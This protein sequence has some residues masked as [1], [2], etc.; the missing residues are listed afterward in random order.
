M[1]EKIIG[2]LKIGAIIFILSLI[3][4]YLFQFLSIFSILPKTEWVFYLCWAALILG[5]IGL[6]V[7]GGMILVYFI[8]GFSLMLRASDKILNEENKK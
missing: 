3:V 4:K 1:S 6:L 7:G 2:K 8:K 5:T